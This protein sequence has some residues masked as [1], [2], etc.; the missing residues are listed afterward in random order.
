ME[1][2]TGTQV[3]Q[4]P[5]AGIKARKMEGLAAKAAA[6]GYIPK[7]YDICLE[8]I[9]RLMHMVFSLDANKAFEAITIA[10]D[11]G[12]AMGHRATKRGRVKSG[13]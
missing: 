9:D 7:E 4:A 3:Q 10:F 5:A 12:F 11:Y 6:C 1:T 2:R 13:L 8:E